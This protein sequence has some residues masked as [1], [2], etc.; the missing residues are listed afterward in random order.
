MSASANGGGGT[1]GGGLSA[2]LGGAGAN[3][4]FGNGGG[5]NLGVTTPSVSTPGIPGIPGTPSTP[6]GTRGSGVTGNNSF[7]PGSAFSQLSSADIRRFRIRCMEVTANPFSYDRN[8][9]AMCRLLQQSA[10]R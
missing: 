7:A 4:G 5:L 10:M 9:V 1:G 6:G 2:G 8:L 3:A